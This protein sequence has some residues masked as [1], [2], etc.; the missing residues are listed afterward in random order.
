M[1]YR[2]Y[3]RRLWFAYWL[4]VS[5]LLILLILAFT[6]VEPLV[7]PGSMVGLLILGIVG[8]LGFVIDAFVLAAIRNSPDKQER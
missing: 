5:L 8:V 6:G 3:R 4:G 2:R 7:G 1:N